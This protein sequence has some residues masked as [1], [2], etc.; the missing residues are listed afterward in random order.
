[1]TYSIT[2]PVNVPSSTTIRL[3]VGNINN[4]IAASN[5]LSVQVTTKDT[6]G[7]VIDLGTSAAY[8]IKQIGAADISDNAITSIKI[9]DGQINTA[10]IASGAVSTPKIA[11]GAVLPVVT[12]RLSDTEIAAPGA[13]NGVTARCYAGEVHTGGGYKVLDS[14]PKVV[15]VFS[16][17]GPPSAWT[18]TVVNTD[19]IPHDFRAYVE[20]LKLI[21]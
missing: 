4:P 1:L 3:E 18:V 20:C 10:D 11:P 7:N 14:S 13:V 19:T 15:T 6:V 21:P 2:S 5:S 17:Q 16:G 12:E 8:S 9:Q